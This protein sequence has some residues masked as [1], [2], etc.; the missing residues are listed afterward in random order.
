MPQ[1]PA[2]AR[3]HRAHGLLLAALLGLPLAS[4]A[5]QAPAPRPAAVPV[6]PLAVQAPLSEA[7][8]Q[9]ATLVHVGTKACDQGRSVHIEPVAD[10]PGYFNL[11]MGG[12][13]YRMR[14]VQTT[15]GAVR[16]EDSAQGAVWIQLAN[17]SMLMNQRASRRLADECANDIQRA[18]AEARRLNPGPSLFDVAKSVPQQP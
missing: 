14:P 11:T 12:Q 9:V 15:T 10:A 6:A 4:L 2:P 7:E 13:R 5:Q 1:Q 3:F 18:A 16:L 8:L 17:K